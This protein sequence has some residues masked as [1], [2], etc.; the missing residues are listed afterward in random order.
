M[1]AMRRNTP[2]H[3]PDATASTYPELP[4]DEDMGTWTR[5]CATEDV[6]LEE[7]IRFDHGGRTFLVIRSPEDEFFCIDGICTHEHVHLADGLVMD[8]IIECPKHSAQFDYKT[9][10]AMRA[11][12]CI[13]L[14]T[15]PVKVEGGD[16]FI[17]I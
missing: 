10:E 14:R 7:Q 15:W 5:A 11:P 2:V 6:E 1:T 12:A 4:K 3:R 17:E 8:G 16:V 9:G 13:N